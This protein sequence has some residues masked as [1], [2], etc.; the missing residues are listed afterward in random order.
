MPQYCSKVKKPF[1]AIDD[2][3]E[4]AHT[5]CRVKQCQV[6]P[7]LVFGWSKPCS[8][9]A[10][11]PLLVA[12]KWKQA[13]DII[14]I[15]VG[16]LAIIS[17]LPRRKWLGMH[18]VARTR[19]GYLSIIMLIPIRY[20]GHFIYEYGIRTTSFFILCSMY[21]QQPPRN[22]NYIQLPTVQVFL[23]VEFI[24]PCITSILLD[25]PSRHGISVL[26]HRLL[27]N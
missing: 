17:F 15:P 3:R 2:W 20:L 23:F 22:V 16:K 8:P 19:R 25:I 10:V 6:V 27:K 5:K 24:P 13:N 21:I 1:C 4:H 26:C 11:C 18:Q 12:Q 7:L 9:Y 14:H